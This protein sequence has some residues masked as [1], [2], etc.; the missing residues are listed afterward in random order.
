MTHT[1]RLQ[2]FG[3]LMVVSACAMAALLAA[4]WQALA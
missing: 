3:A 2:A 4:A 1:K